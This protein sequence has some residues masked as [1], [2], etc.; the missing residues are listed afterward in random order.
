MT[1]PTKK[2]GEVCEIVK[3]GVNRFDGEK[4]Y[5]DTG[6]L[7]KNSIV[8]PELVTYSKRPSRANMA[9]VAGDVL[10]AK[11]QNTHKVYIATEKDEKRRIFS[12]GF[13]ILRPDRKILNSN[14]LYFYLSSNLFQ[15]LKDQKAH[16]ATQKAINNEDLNRYFE[17]PLPPLSEQKKIVAKVEK[18]FGKIKEAERLRA[19][20][21]TAAENLLS[22]ELHKIFSEG[23]KK[24]WQEK[25]LGEVCEVVGGGTPSTS[26]SE[27]WG[28]KYAW[29]TPKDLGKLDT[30]EIGKT[31][32]TITIEGLKNSSAKLL[33]VGSVILSSRAPIGYVAINNVEMATNQGCRSFVCGNKI[34]N[35]FLYYFLDHNTELLRL[36]GSGSTFS[37]ISGSKLKKIKIPLPFVAEQKKIVVRLDA[38]TAKARELKI[39]QSQT[40]ENLKELKQSILQKSFKG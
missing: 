19:E 21:K 6:S 7:V 30:V 8:N 2:L 38:L 16:G 22:A 39:L 17:I 5:I 36:H 31:N 10:V 37:E 29:V 35:R 40:A 14:Y 33:P 23:K 28:G 1:Y 12:T 25:E 24:S 13:F 20:A 9:A 11:M 32:K 3:S 15:N 4:E 18:L 27:Y 34:Y 26:Q